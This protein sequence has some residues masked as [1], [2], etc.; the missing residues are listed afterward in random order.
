MALS[1][2]IV[3]DHPSFRASARMLLESEGYQV[4]GEAAD[5]EGAIAA[6]RDLAPDLVLL[7]VQLPGPRR[8]RGVRPPQRA[9]ATRPRW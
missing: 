5:G 1:V 9:T 4:V 3:D 2:L 6:V 8:L 7:D